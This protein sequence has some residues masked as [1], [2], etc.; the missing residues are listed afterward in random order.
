MTSEVGAKHKRV[1]TRKSREEYF[2]K[3]V[4]VNSVKCYGDVKQDGTEE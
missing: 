4:G 2:K 3:E 1:A